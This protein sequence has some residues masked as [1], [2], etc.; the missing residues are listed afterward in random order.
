MANDPTISIDDNVA[1][2]EIPSGWI[3]SAMV[4]G[5]TN[6]SAEQHVQ[7]NFDGKDHG[8]MKA[9]GEQKLF[10]PVSFPPATRKAIIT[11]THG[12]DKK[13]ST[14]RAFPPVTDMRGR[15]K[16]II[17]YA[18]NGDDED[19]NDVQFTIRGFP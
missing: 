11:F 17:I 9:T 14:L 5:V 12:S 19:F 4:E 2:I 1:T 16:G 13:P 15:M 10:K 18:E 7:L 8:T 3:S 6:S